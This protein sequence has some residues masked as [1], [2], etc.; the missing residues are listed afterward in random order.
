MKVNYSQI[1]FW[2]APVLIST[3]FEYLFFMY[4]KSYVSFFQQGE[5]FKFG[6][7]GIKK[8]QNI[9]DEK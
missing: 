6:L 8:I 7:E 3:L 9:E 4:R 2:I 1:I 5:A